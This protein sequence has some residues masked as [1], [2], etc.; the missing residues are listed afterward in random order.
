M[1]FIDLDDGHSDLKSEMISACQLG[2]FKGHN[3]KF[4]PTA[5]LTNAQALAV[6]VRLVDGMKS[7]DGAHR[8]DNY[9]VTARSLGLTK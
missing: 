1:L 7:E 4:M 9:L 3:G 6:L 2:L 8:A 5:L